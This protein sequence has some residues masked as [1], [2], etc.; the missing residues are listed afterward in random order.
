MRHRAI[1]LSTVLLLLVATPLLGQ[2][3]GGRGGGFASAL[4][5]P[6]THLIGQEDLNL[7]DEQ[8]E[9]LEA[10]AAELDETNEADVTPVREGM[11]AARSGGGGREAFQALRPILAAIR[12][13]NEAAVESAMTILTEEQTPIAHRLLEELAA[14]GRGRRGG[15]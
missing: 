15:G 9:A 11:E 5:N 14:Q 1:F 2:R 8:T 10:V 7:T 4:Q 12:E 13:R 3:R 6:I